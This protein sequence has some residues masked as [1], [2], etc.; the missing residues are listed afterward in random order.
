MP[1]IDLS[2][3]KFR[4][5]AEGEEPTDFGPDIYVAPA[6]SRIIDLSRIRFRPWENPGASVP[7]GF[8]PDGD[9]G[10]GGP[11]GGDQGEFVMRAYNPGAAGHNVA[12]YNF[13]PVTLVS[14]YVEI[15]ITQEWSDQFAASSSG[16]PYTAEFLSLA[17]EDNPLFTWEGL[18]FTNL[19]QDGDPDGNVYMW[20]YYDGE[21]NKFMV[22][23]DVWHTAEISIFFAAGMYFS[24]VWWDG[25]GSPGNGGT[26][27]ALED[28]IAPG[29]TTLNV[30]A[31]Y[32][33]FVDEQEWYLDNAKLT[34]GN[35]VTDGGTV[36]FTGDFEEGDF[37]DWTG[38]V[39]SPTVVNTP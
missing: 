27:I 4:P 8:D 35:I 15:M 37:S 19:N 25:E 5:Y 18:F 11:G 7:G 10:G 34:F 3:I 16:N 26:I 36:V 2:S 31:Q 22:T 12:Y 21:E 29:I 39:G 14:A 17:S 20:S 28:D 32:P 1:A 23:P 13:S 33:N 38:T 9:D 24:G 30:G 6:G